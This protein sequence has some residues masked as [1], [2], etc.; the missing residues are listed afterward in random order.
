[1]Q[2]PRSLPGK[3]YACLSLRKMLCDSVSNRLC[4]TALLFNAS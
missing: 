3:L 2:A 4:W 1:M